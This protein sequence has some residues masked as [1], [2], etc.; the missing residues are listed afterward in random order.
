[1][2]EQVTPARIAAARAAPAS[3]PAPVPVAA[4]ALPAAKPAPLA[5]AAPKAPAPAP[6]PAAVAAA[7]PKPAPALTAPASST[8][9]RVEA[10]AFSARLL[11][12]IDGRT[13]GEV[14]FQ[15]TPAGLKVRLGSVAEVLANRLPASEL[16]RIRGS[17]AGN[18]WL[19]LAELQAQGIPISYDPVYDEFNIGRE[20]TRPKA[21]RKVHI[22]QISTPERGAGAGTMDQIRRR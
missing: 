13:S 5:A 17:A 21:A 15:Q 12:R 6:L 14:D 8:P 19:S 2:I 20:D 1:M 9:P 18:A 11:T 22:D 16:A 4:A 3:A 10:P 7:V